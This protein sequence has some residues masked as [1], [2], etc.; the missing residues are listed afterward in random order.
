MAIDLLKYMVWKNGAGGGGASY[1]KTV[2]PAPIISISDAKAKPAKSLVVGMEPI[3]DLHGYENPWPA[4]GGKNK[5]NPI[6]YTGFP[7]IE[8]GI[9]AVLNNDGTFTL[10]GTAE[11]RTYIILCRM[12]F[13]AGTIL[14]GCPTGGTTQTYLM[15]VDGTTVVDYGSGSSISSD[16]TQGMLQ[17]VIASGY[18]CNNLT[19]KPMV[20]LAS[21][22]DATYAPYSNL[23]PI[24]G[25][26]GVTV[27]HSGVDTSDPQT[28]P[29]VFPDSAGTV[30]GGT[31]DLVSG[32][33]TVTGILE[34]FNRVNGSILNSQMNSLP[35]TGNSVSTI[36]DVTRISF[37][38]RTDVDQTKYNR[39][40]SSYANDERMCNMASHYFAYNDTST[41]WYR[42]TIL[43]VF[44]P[45]A[46]VGSTQESVYDYLVSIKDT[47]PLSLYVPLAEPQTFQL[48][49]QQI[50]M[51]KGANV[52]WSDANDLTLTYMAKKE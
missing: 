22:A 38:V 35:R 17:V 7:K 8:S 25:R 12:D 52:L 26:T 36:G 27:Y 18:T 46:L 9:T 49:P 43:Y 34:Q 2:G 40:S 45:T 44:L 23:C 42:N 32:V 30:Y 14:N 21:V 20:R 16:I 10:N 29:V 24:T 31:V 28:Y 33:L 1:E 39:I 51:L 41:H 11:R 48:T 4:G 47:N 37:N 50:Q 19:F 15:G 3:Q 5:I 13:S 6:L